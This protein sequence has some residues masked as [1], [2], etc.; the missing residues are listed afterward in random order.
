MVREEVTG[1]RGRY[2]GS[3]VE[4]AAPCLAR[5]STFVSSNS[6]MGRNPHKT[7]SVTYIRHIIEGGDDIGSGAAGAPPYL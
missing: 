3:E 1:H 4:A 6:S 5:V 2:G 7:D